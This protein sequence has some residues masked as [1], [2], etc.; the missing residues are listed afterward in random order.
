MTNRKDKNEED[1]NDDFVNLSVLS[2]AE[3]R[4][5]M[6]RNMLTVFSMCENKPLTYEEVNDY[7][8]SLYGKYTQSKTTC[9]YWR[10]TLANENIPASCN[11]PSCKETKSHRICSKKFYRK[12]K[13]IW[14][15][16]EIAKTLFKEYSDKWEKH[17]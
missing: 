3:Q 7:L 6:Y 8:Y 10:L 13:V 12:T 14:V 4:S 11:D 5:R 9:V 15:Q 1:I 16:R 2:S 17:H